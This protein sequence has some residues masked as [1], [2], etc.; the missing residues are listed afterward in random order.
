M[1]RNAML[2]ALLAGAMTLATLNL[3]IAQTPAIPHGAESPIYRP[4]LSD[5]MTATIQP[6][7]IKLGL[8]GREKNWPHAAY[9][10]GNLK[11]AFDRTALAWPMYRTTNMA[12][13]IEATIKPPM[14]AVA[15]AIKAGDPGKFDEAY[16][17]LTGTCN[18]CHQS[19]DHGL[20]VIRVPKASPY[21]DQDFR[22]TKP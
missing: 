6:R 13:L 22:P 10:L 14:D 2:L 19:T 20:V 11:G 9:E 7:H 12:D 16:E 5:L 3:G 1:L 18:A 8:A 15:T 21:P 4:S 17:Q